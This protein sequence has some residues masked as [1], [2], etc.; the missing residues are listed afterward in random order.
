MLLDNFQSKSISSV[1]KFSFSFPIFSK[2]YILCKKYCAGCW[3]VYNDEYSNDS[4]SLPEYLCS[5]GE[6]RC[7]H[8]S[9]LF[10]K[11]WNNAV[12]EKR[13]SHGTEQR[14]VEWR[15]ISATCNNLIKHLYLTRLIQIQ[16]QYWYCII[17]IWSMINM[18]SYHINDMMDE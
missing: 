2:V 12:V 8:N 17:S 11:E 1:L 10:K 3:G 16:Y 14:N 5:I 9:L 7:I 15:L 18:I 4:N 13:A 6:F